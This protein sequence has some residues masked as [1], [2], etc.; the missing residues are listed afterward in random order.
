MEPAAPVPGHPERGVGLELHGPD[1]ALVVQ[2]GRHVVVLVQL[3]QVAN[4]AVDLFKFSAP[5]IDRVYLADR[6]RPDPLARAP[7]GCAG[8]ALVAELRHYLILARGRHEGAYLVDA[9]GERLFAIDVLA[10]LHGFH[11]D[12]RVA[13]VGRANDDAVDLL[14]HLVEHFAIVDEALR[15]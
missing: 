5:G 10:A 8:V 15:V 12:D 3:V 2:L 13:V 6:S 1:P 7:N 14:A 4:L 9:V 11:G